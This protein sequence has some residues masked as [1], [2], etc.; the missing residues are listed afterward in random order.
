MY[1][2]ICLVINVQLNGHFI[3][4]LNCFLICLFVT[5]SSLF[6]EPLI[7]CIHIVVFIDLISLY[8]S[9]FEIIHY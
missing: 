8:V 4:N 7:S 9:S 5:I 6:Q 1:I 2:A 3:G